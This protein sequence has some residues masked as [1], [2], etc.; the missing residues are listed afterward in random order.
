MGP[1]APHPQFRFT[2][3]KCRFAKN[4]HMENLLRGE[5][6]LLRSP[7]PSDTKWLYRWENDPGI[8]QAGQTLV[9]F[10]KNTLRQYIRNSRADI[11]QTRQVR[12]MITTLQNNK[13]IGTIDLFDY[14]PI[15]GR[16]G[17]GILI[18]EPEE[19]GRGY[20][21]EA[22]SL[23]LGYCE[24]V[25]LMHQVW[26]TVRADNRKSLNLFLH[27]GF[28]QTGIRRKWILTPEG[29]QDEVFLQFFLDSPLSAVVAD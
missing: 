17:T 5:N 1:V 14:E 15:F 3:K 6:I 12:F 20:A 21:R 27:A 2:E 16:A 25:L 4:H 28:L 13:T 9:P 18:A 26:C 10:S 19:R 7:E 24:K 29:W 11:F 22:L 23:L 8:W